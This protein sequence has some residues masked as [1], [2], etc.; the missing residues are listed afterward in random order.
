MKL[1][2]SIIKGLKRREL[3]AAAKLPDGKIWRTH[4]LKGWGRS[5]NYDGR[6]DEGFRWVGWLPVPPELGDLIE[7]QTRSGLARFKV[8]EV[9]RVRDPDDMFWALT[10]HQGYL[11]SEIKA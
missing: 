11:V 2:R 4:E 3:R 6:E 7:H 8:I 1:P 10:P 5:L 9:R